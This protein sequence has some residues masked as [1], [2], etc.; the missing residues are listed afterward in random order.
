MPNFVNYKGHFTNRVGREGEG[1]CMLVRNDVPHDVLAL[2]PYGNGKLDIQAVKIY[3]N[4]M[5]IMVVASIYNAGGTV[6]LHEFNFYFSQLGNKGVIVGDFNAHHR[7]WNTRHNRYCSTGQ[8]LARAIAEN[9]FSQL[10]YVNM[11]T[12][13]SST[14]GTIS[15]LDL[16]FLSAQ[17][18]DRGQIELGED[19]R[20]DHCPIKVKISIS[21]SSATFRS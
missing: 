2:T 21:E 17:L 3:K 4:N 12:F 8:N 18:F 6:T 16:C 1:I 13:I 10:T 11:P 15:T 7:N 9:H 14:N 19:C 5:E 20:S